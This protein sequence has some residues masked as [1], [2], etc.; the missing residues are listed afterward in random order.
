MCEPWGSCWDTKVTK[1]ATILSL[2]VNGPTKVQPCVGRLEWV[3]VG[4]LYPDAQSIARATGSQLEAEVSGPPAARLHSRSRRGAQASRSCSQ[5]L[6]NQR[7]RCLRGTPG[8][9]AER[10]LPS[11]LPGAAGLRSPVFLTRGLEF[12]PSPAFLSSMLQ[13]KIQHLK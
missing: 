6:W 7:Q 8:A 1:V 3:G 10:P 9:E 4:V 11:L 12:S 5:L 2:K 13:G